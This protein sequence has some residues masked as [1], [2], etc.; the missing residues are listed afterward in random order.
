METECYPCIPMHSASNQKRLN[1]STVTMIKTEPLSEDVKI[2]VDDNV[3]QE[4]SSYNKLASANSSSSSM[5]RSSLLHHQQNK[6][7]RNSNAK[8][9][10]NLFSASQQQQQRMQ[11]HTIRLSRVRTRPQ[12]LDFA[13]FSKIETGSL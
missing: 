12:L 7:S 10:N 6:S 5:N 3:N 8:K 4:D 11:Q 9:V 13:L 1:H 2:V